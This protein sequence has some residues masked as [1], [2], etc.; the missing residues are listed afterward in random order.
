MERRERGRLIVFEGAD[1]VGKTTLIEEFTSRL[2][3]SGVSSDHLAFPGKQPGTLGRLVYD[4]H[5]DEVSWTCPQ[6]CQP[7]KSSGATHRGAY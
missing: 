6:R 7:G 5:H 1:K 2:R 3:E 4:L